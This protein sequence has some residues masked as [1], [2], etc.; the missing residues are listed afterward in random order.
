K[1]HLETWA[2][3][4]SKRSWTKMD[5]PQE[6]TPSG[7]R[8]RLLTF[9]PDHGVA[10]LENRTHPPTAPAEQQVWTYRYA[11]PP[12]D[13]NPPAPPTGVRLA[14]GKDAVTLGWKASTSKGVERYAVYRGEGEQPWKAE[15]RRVGAVKAGEGEGLKYVD[16]SVKPGVV[17][18]YAVAAE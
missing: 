1:A 6:P 9:L 10:L 3:D 7:S 13:R 16:R 17:Y 12:A 8:A 11:F 2:F 4:P 14:A 5:P 15:L 18:H